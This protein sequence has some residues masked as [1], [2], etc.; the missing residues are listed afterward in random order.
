MW[1]AIAAVGQKAIGKKKE[2]QAQAAAQAGQFAQ[3]MMGQSQSTMQQHMSMDYSQ[4]P[5][6]KD[7]TQ[8][9]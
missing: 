5:S 4:I 6:F 8:F 9:K 3:G 1:G 7:F 2:E